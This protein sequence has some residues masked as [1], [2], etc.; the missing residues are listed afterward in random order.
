MGESNLESPTH[1]RP[2]SEDEGY[3]CEGQNRKWSKP[4]PPS[5]SRVEI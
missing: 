5:K 3:V 1:P 4:G 2:V